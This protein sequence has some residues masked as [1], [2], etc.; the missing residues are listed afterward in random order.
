M[1]KL[2]PSPLP[3]LAQAPLA[4]GA[5]PRRTQEQRSDESEQRLLIAAA[6]LIEREGFAAVT[7]DRVGALAGYSR[8]LAAHKFGSKDGLVRAVIGFVTA[9]VQQQVDARLAGY[10]DPVDRL[11]NWT[12]VMLAEVAADPLLRA[13]FV[14]MAA[15]VGNR[16]EIRTEFL[17][18]HEGVRAELRS[19]IEEGQRAGSIAAQVDA[20]ALALAI[21]SLHLGISVELLL[22]PDLDM[23]ALRR[24][25]R[26]SISRMLT[27]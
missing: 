13:Y 26:E 2:M 4:A 5:A 7:F 24:S 25:V 1:T 19:M 12:D 27:P 3:P 11:L 10:A 22:D 8:G 23:D 20:D 15:A 16:A 6:T 14:M 21:G 17:A 9:R 18:A